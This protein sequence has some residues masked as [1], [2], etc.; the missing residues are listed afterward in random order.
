MNLV[1]MDNGLVMN[2]DPNALQVP[3][4]VSVHSINCEICEKIERFGR[5]GKCNMMIST[6]HCE[7]LLQFQA[8]GRS[9]MAA[10]MKV[11]VVGLAFS[12]Q[13]GFGGMLFSASEEIGALF[14][15][16]A[17]VSDPVI[18]WLIKLVEISR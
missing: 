12:S 7:E 4:L 18:N 11:R 15:G 10:K 8:A 14:S 3:F 16:L 17:E 5:L 13:A 1:S 2:E 6:Y 9:L